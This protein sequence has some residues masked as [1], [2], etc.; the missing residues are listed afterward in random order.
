[1]FLE[2]FITKALLIEASKDGKDSIPDYRLNRDVKV[3]LFFPDG[4][5]IFDSNRESVVEIFNAP[6][7]SR[8]ENKIHRIR[9]SG[10]N[11]DIFLVLPEDDGTLR[12]RF[13]H[14]GV[15]I[16]GKEFIKKLETK[17]PELY[18]NSLML[19]KNVVMTVEGESDI[20]FFNRL[21]KDNDSKFIKIPSSISDKATPEEISNINKNDF[22]ALISR[23]NRFNI[24]L[25]V[26][27]GVSIPFGSDS[28][29][30]MV[31][32][33]IDF[34]K[35][36][37][38]EEPEKIKKSL[39]YS[40]YGITSFVKNTTEL[41][42]S[43]TDYHEY[44]RYCIY[45]KYNNIMHKE[46]T[47]VKYIALGKERYPN[48][49]ILSYNFDTFVERQYFKSF[50]KELKYYSGNAYK[51]HLLDSV[52]HLHGYI[53]YTENNVKDIILTADDYYAAYLDSRSWVVN[54]Q[55]EI[56]KDYKCLYVGSSLSDLFQMSL[57]KEVSKN[58]PKWECFALMCF[59]DM[60]Y[61]DK[62]RLLDYYAKLGVRV[63]FVDDFSKLP[64]MLKELLSV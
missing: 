19:D 26:G 2:L 48:M 61:K 16:L 32:N 37:W 33:L 17:Y 41:N 42:L 50:G 49:P 8:I 3:D 40:N 11:G 34:L 53:S 6:S 29:E 14:F 7:E 38:V 15:R 28:W 58:D 62:M 1:M 56:L 59:N 60:K 52:I 45:R 21:I 51:G 25:I 44:I 30:K 27:N 43:K 64:S 57:I 23:N 24:A 35:P 46:D 31:D 63:I 9:K 5:N 10:F 4:L 47:L 13:E 18:V 54:I 22:Q 20:N 36:Q 39:S 12:N 55:K